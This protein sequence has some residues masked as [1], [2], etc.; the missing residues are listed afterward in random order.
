MIINVGLID[1][2]LRLLLALF[3]LEWFASVYPRSLEPQE[4]WGIWLIGIYLLLSGVFRVC[5]IYR[6]FNFDSCARE[7]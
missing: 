6:I 5:P 4:R 1:R 7:P 2:T 3:L